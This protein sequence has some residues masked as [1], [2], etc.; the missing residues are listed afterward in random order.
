MGDPDFIFINP[1]IPIPVG[2]ANSLPVG[3][4]EDVSYIDSVGGNSSSCDLFTADDDD[5]IGDDLVLLPNCEVD[6]DIER[7][8][9]DPDRDMVVVVV[10]GVGLDPK[11]P[12]LASN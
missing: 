3:L 1:D 12:V 8:E 11:K 6:N 10:G 9:L 7:E 5:G 2:T 4:N